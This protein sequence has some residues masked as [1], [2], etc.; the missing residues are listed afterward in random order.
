MKSKIHLHSI[1]VLLILFQFRGNC[2]VSISNT[3]SPPD[4]SA[5]LDIK[6]SEKGLLVPRMT[7]IQRAG[8]TDP[9]NALLI[10]QTDSPVGFYFNQGSPVTPSWKLL[11]S[12]PLSDCESRIPISSLPFTI[13]ES[14]SYYLTESIDAG[15][16]NG[17]TISASNVTLDLNGYTLLSDGSG[18]LSA[19]YCNA[20]ISNLVIR[21][22]IISNW[23]GHGINGVNASHCNITDMQISD[24]KLTGVSV[25]I[26]SRIENCTATNNLFDGINTK[27]QGL[28]I[29]CI[30]SNN[31]TEGIDVNANSIVSTCVVSNNG[32]N[33]IEASTKSEVTHCIANDNTED[34]IEVAAGGMINSCNAN[35]NGENGFDISSGSN[36]RNSTARANTQN[37]YKLNSDVFA[38]NNSADNNILSGFLLTGNDARLDNNH[39]TDNIQNGF[40][41]TLSNNVFIRNTTSGNSATAFNITAGNTVGTILTTGTL[42]S[43]T[44]PFANISF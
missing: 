29:N 24:C 39:S 20:S 27:N 1:I 42:N 7:S 19:V 9:A 17:I 30:A 28:V 14:G 3:S 4:P 37:G 18:P 33:G 21:N 34:G 35:S 41:A 25:G 32:A 2:Q 36:I 43:N 23:G 40:Q 16:S 8:I 26:N 44:N 31:G 10:Y 12:D 6:G 38:S 11:S 13:T 22:G 15:G 5:M